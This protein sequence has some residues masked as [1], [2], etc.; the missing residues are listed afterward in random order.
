M[1]KPGDQQSEDGVRREGPGTRGRLLRYTFGLAAAAAVST[2][3]LLADAPSG[4][5]SFNTVEPLWDTFPTGTY[6]ED[7]RGRHAGASPDGARFYALRDGTVAAYRASDGIELW[8]HDVLDTGL[9]PAE[10]VALEVSAL[11]TVA[12]LGHDT[13]IDEVF[14]LAIHG[15][16]GNQLWRRAVFPPGFGLT[17]VTLALHAG[18]ARLAVA[19]HWEQF[20]A[21]VISI[22][23]V[24]T[25]SEIHQVQ[26]PGDSS[27][28][29]LTTDIAFSPDGARVYA[30]MHQTLGSGAASQFLTVAV[31]LEPSIVYAWQQPFVNGYTSG[32]TL[33]PFGHSTPRA[34]ALSPDGTQVAVTGITQHVCNGDTTPEI[35]ETRLIA[36]A[37]DAMTGA[38]QWTFAPHAEGGSTA[39]DPCFHGH[40]EGWDVVVSSNQVVVTG[41]HL[42]FSSTLFQQVTIALD[43]SSGEPVWTNLDEE[44]TGAGLLHARLLLTPDESL[45][46]V[47]GSQ[48]VAPPGSGCVAGSYAR[49]RGISTAD[50]DLLQRDLWLLD[51]SADPQDHAHDAALSPDG[52]HVFAV[53]HRGLDDTQALTALSLDGSVPGGDPPPGGGVDPVDPTGIY[54]TAELAADDGFSHPREMVDADGTLFFIANPISLSDF[55]PRLY[56]IDDSMATSTLVKDF[57]QD[58]DLGHPTHVN[59]LVFFRATANSDPFLGSELWKSDGTTEGTA[60]VKDIRLGTNGSSLLQLT[61]VGNMLFFRAS[62]GVNGAELWKS[63]GTEAG[64]VMVKDINAGVNGSNPSGLADVNGVLFFSANDGVHGSELWKSDG[65]SAGTVMVRDI[66]FGSSTPASLTVLGSTLLFTASTGLGRELW[67]TDG[68]AAGTVLVKDIHTGGS[69]NPNRLTRVGGTLFF[70]ADDGVHGRELWRSD[71]TAEGTVLVKDIRPGSAGSAAELLVDAGGTLFFTADDGVHGREVWK[72]DGTPAG[73]VMVKDIRPGPGDGIDLGWAPSLVA[74]GGLVFFPATDGNNEIELWKSNGTEA[75]TLLVADIPNPNNVTDS[76][77]P[78]ELTAVGDTLYFSAWDGVRDDGSGGA[79]RR[80]YRVRRDAVV[81]PPPDPGD[82]PPD[83]SLWV[84]CLH[85]P[86]LPEAGQPVTITAEA[87]VAG[88]LD[89][90]T[91]PISV[92]QIDILIADGDGRSPRATGHDVDTLTFETTAVPLPPTFMMTYG[93]RVRVGEEIVFSGWRQ[94]STIEIDGARP[95]IFTGDRSERLDILFVADDSS[96]LNGASDTQFLDDVLTMIRD[97]FYDFPVFGGLGQRT[98]GDRFNFWIA[99][100]TGAAQWDGT[101]CDHQRPDTWLRNYSF[102]DAAAVLHTQ[103]AFRDCAMPERRIFSTRTTRSD[104]PAV[105]RHEAGHQPFG[106]ADEYCG[107]VYA[108]SNGGTRT[109]R[110]DGGQFQAR[111]APNVYR[112]LRACEEDTADFFGRSPSD[113]RSLVNTATEVTWYLS[114]PDAV[115]DGAVLDGTHDLM[116]DEGRANGSDR[117]R[118]FWMYQRCAEGKC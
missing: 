92:D 44:R 7:I 109:A 15:E 95:V 12:V 41:R 80:L 91:A 37:Y 99:S 39:G 94:T 62:D 1:P 48:D 90:T 10:L 118:I 112:T 50:G 101:K 4:H 107:Q 97:G 30:L 77:I 23:D 89:I 93:C 36:A 73:T 114:D 74:I 6:T 21:G 116:M 76:S 57:G 106:L 60:L 86:L 18:S 103:A 70:V 81:D 83:G 25:G 64:T 117:R 78:Q 40:D 88:I 17:P 100:H 29:T 16:T 35:G 63:D 27:A 24:G 22:L 20:D 53:V 75:G 14:V 87:R 65:T 58:P 34:L 68:T 85:S 45:A 51:C 82:P 113:C 56:R 33:V 102:A 72:S 2:F 28:P 32:G 42:P 67:K 5:H 19:M 59:G 43:R 115:P 108:L 104:A 54:T 52:N 105:L 79:R 8:T 61:A 46:I 38:P 3:A 96:Y 71:G 11:G 55:Y 84:R 111:H 98:V 66:Q 47:T 31:D 26:L 9:D 49:I 13:A 110:C 69:S